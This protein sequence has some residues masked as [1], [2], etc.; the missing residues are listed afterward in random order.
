MPYRKRTNKKRQKRSA[1]PRRMNYNKLIRTIKRVDTRQEFKRSPM[2]RIEKSYD[3]WVGNNGVIPLTRQD[4]S[5]ALCLVQSPFQ[6]MPLQVGALDKNQRLSSVVYPQ[7]LKFSAMLLCDTARTQPQRFR[8]SVIRYNG[9]SDI[10]TD[11]SVYHGWDTTDFVHACK[12]GQVWSSKPFVKNQ[13]KVLY[14]REYVVNDSNKTGVL[15]KMSLPIKRKLT[16][17]TTGSGA[18][19]VGAGNIY[20][21][22]SS[23]NDY[24]IYNYNTFAFYKDL[25]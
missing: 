24:N 18:A 9:E 3:S 20:I 21:L 13:M 14:D 8:V 1:G 4:F 7:V 15:C 19:A 10:A 12:P 6:D 16:F 5:S 2:L 23:D 22:I 11:N 25:Q 17:E